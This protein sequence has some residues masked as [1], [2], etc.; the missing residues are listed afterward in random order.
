MCDVIQID[1]GAD[2]GG[3]F[4]F[5]FRCV[6]GGEHDI[7][8]GDSK[9]LREHQLCHGG[10][11]AATAVLLQNVDQKRIWGRLYSEKFFIALIPGKCLC[12]ALLHSH[13]SLFH[14]RDETESDT[15]W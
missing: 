9:R 2:I 3:L 6:I 8:A 4:E 10:T 13:E 14:R 5:F 1:D 7:M 15:F 11:V 12:T